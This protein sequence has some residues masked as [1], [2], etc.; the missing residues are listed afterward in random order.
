MSRLAWAVALISSLSACTVP[1]LGSDEQDVKVDTESEY[2]WQQYLA[3]LEFAKSYEPRCSFDDS[4]GP[5]DVQHRVLVTGFGRFLSNSSNATGEMVSE[6]LDELNYPLTEAPPAG[7][8]DKPAAQTRV[9]QGIIV[10]PGAG[11]V[12][13]CAM[14]L[15]VFWDLAPYL[16]AQEMRSFAPDLVLMNGIARGRQ[17]VWLELGA[18]NLAQRTRDGSGIVVPDEHDAPL[19]PTASHDEYARPNLASWDAMKASID[20]AIDERADIEHE[21]DTF[22]RV[23]TGTSFAGY[24]RSSNTYLCNNTTYTVGYLM[25]HPDETV[26]LLEASHAREGVE[27]G[28]PLALGIDMSEVPR[29]FMHWPTQLKGPFLQAGASVMRAGIDAQLTALAAGKKPTTGEND[30]ADIPANLSIP[31]PPGSSE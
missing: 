10:L 4:T 24:P 20:K 23:L 6:L 26:T 12:A 7:D 15:P 8:V 11:K 17:D 1:E 13:V 29:L 31:D 25:D 3:N 2:S 30:R 9:A 28:L 21:G 14:V 18:V 22:G 16:I 27:T 5:E 19:V